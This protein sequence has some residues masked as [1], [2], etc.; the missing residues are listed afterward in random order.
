MFIIFVYCIIVVY[1]IYYLLYYK[2]KRYYTAQDILWPKIYTFL[3]IMRDLNSSFH[4]PHLKNDE[5]AIQCFKPYSTP[6]SDDFSK[7]LR[8]VLFHFLSRG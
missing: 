6:L 7:T 4:D 1:C 5:V 2:P 8:K 3:L